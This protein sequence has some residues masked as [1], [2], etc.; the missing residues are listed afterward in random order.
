MAK[1][2]VDEGVAMGACGDRVWTKDS[3]SV[4]IPAGP[5]AEEVCM[6]TLEDALD[7]GAF[8]DPDTT[9]EI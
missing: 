7:S 5:T 3:T 9:S 4:R 2:A 8:L 1:A 6:L